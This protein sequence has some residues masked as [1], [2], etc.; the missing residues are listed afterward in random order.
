[1]KWRKCR[2]EGGGGARKYEKEDK[3]AGR[4]TIRNKREDDDRVARRRDGAGGGGAFGR[5]C[6]VAAGAPH[7]LARPAIPTCTSLCLSYVF[8]LLHLGQVE[9]VEAAPSC[10]PLFRS[11]YICRHSLTVLPLSLRHF[12]SAD[13]QGI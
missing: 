9:A 13:S 7:H 3:K 5:L 10:L 6:P 8:R 4:K 11:P 12:N 1:M 2:V